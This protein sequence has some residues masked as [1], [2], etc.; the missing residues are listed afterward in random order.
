MATLVSHALQRGTEVVLLGAR[1][2]IG[3]LHARIYRSLGVR[4]TEVDLPEMADAGRIPVPGQDAIIDVCTPTAAHTTSVRWAY[5]VFGARRFFVEKPAASS[6]SDWRQCLDATP[7]AVVFTGHSYLF[8]ETFRVLA[9]ACPEPAL[10]IA[11]WDKDR[12]ADD[13]RLR[14]AGLDGR[15]PDVWEIEAPHALAAAIALRPGLRLA[16]AQYTR[17]AERAPGSV[18]PVACAARLASGAADVLVTSDLRAPRRRRLE[19]RDSGGGRTV[20]E[21]PLSGTGSARVYR[22]SP[23]GAVILLRQ[24]PDD[25]LRATLM[26]GL[27]ALSRGTVP[28]FASAE[29][30]G[31]V[32]GL[33]DQ[34]RGMAGQ[35][36]SLVP[37]SPREVSDAGP[38][39]CR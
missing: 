36:R 10:V 32:L 39:P 8:S 3:R 1:G 26:A 24:G 31:R 17:L 16:Q 28:P 29:F 35:R 34:A 9:R 25:L 37:R 18:A 14:G 22:Q 12:T 4:V 33:M 5:T 30:A 7:G 23:R 13:R 38:V 27:E 19:L 6:L 20:A 21:F 11:G 2:A 15:L